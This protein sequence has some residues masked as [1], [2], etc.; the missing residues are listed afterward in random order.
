[1]RRDFKIGELRS[2][3]TN[4]RKY[5]KFKLLSR[6]DK[7]VY[8][9]IEKHFN[10]WST[11]NHENRSAFEIAL[12]ALGGKS[13]N[14]VETGTSAWG[15]DSTRIWDTYIRKFGGNLH[16]VDIRGA[17]SRALLFQT[18][19]NTHLVISDSVKFL[20]ENPMPKTDLYFLDSWDLDFS[21]PIPSAIHGMLE[22]MAIKEQLKSGSLLFVDDTPSKLIF[23]DRNLRND[24]F[25]FERLFN[26]VPGKGALIKKYL[27]ANLP[28]EVLH[29]EW[30]FLARIK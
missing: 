19:R 15:T 17:A 22:F 16:S 25:E 8:Q 2:I 11:E 13:A 1:M 28:H 4:I 14:I 21:N 20:A 30:S 18:S 12:I 27:D 6:T 7:D 26:C 24:D 3:Y 5:S 10:F 23:E 9:L 29:H